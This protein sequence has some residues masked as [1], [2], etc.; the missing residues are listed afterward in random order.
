MTDVLL[1]LMATIWGVN[2][3][4]VKSATQAM[5]PATFTTLRIALAALTMYTY[6]A[7]QRNAWPARR[8]W[9]ALAGLGVI[10]NGIYQL[11]FANGV[12]R[13]RVA[14]AAL[15]IAAGPALIAVASHM[16]GIERV[17]LRVATG[18]ALTIVGV[19]TVIIG[20]SALPHRDGTV[21][22]AALMICALVCWTIFSVGLRRYSVRIDPVQL[23]AITMTGGLLPMIFVTPTLV[24]THWSSI[25][26]LIWGC[27]LYASV[28]SMGVAYVFYMRGLRVLG[29]TRSAIYGNLQP[30]IA[31]LFAWAFLG[32]P[33]TPWQGVGA[34]LIISGIILTRT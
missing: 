29:P 11:F 14:D 13:T 27:V 3:S 22:G 16:L 28:L 2:F 25:T 31:I 4:A 12:A 21:L 10:G 7:F 30:P 24:T 1:F 8:D 18:I 26:P 34:A 20:S 5:P 32:E 23:N 19:A 15:I 17:T 33:P 9:I 6:A